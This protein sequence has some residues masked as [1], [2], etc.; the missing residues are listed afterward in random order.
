MNLEE[1]ELAGNGG[2][3]CKEWTLQGMR[4]HR[5]RAAS[6]TRGRDNIAVVPCGHASI[7]S[8]SSFIITPMAAHIKY[9]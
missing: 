6:L 7:S 4:L 8:S 9:T 2:G 3:I 5:A 1:A